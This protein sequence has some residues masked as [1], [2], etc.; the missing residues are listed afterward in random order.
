MIIV[1]HGAFG[2]AVRQ[3]LVAQLPG[4]RVM[5]LDEA[6]HHAWDG[7]SGE[8]VA[9]ALSARPTIALQRLSDRFQAAR[10][11]HSMVVL[12]DHLLMCGPLVIPGAGPCL[13]CALRRFASMVEKPRTARQDQNLNAFIEAH[14]DSE[15][16]GHLPTLVELAALKLL[17]HGRC[18]AGD[19]GRLSALSLVDSRT[20]ESR[21]IALHGCTCRSLPRASLEERWLGALRPAL[22]GLLQ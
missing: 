4:A 8:F 11:A 14:P 9:L 21:V 2:L 6:R 7:E 13:R 1:H 15:L 10:L 19:A 12:S 3:T 18:R 22:D 5:T 20:V 16:P 17:Q